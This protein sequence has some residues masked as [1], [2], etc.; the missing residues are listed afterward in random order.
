VFTLHLLLAGPLVGQAFVTAVLAYAEAR[1]EGGNAALAE[2][3][4]PLDGILDACRARSLVRGLRARGRLPRFVPIVGDWQVVEDGGR[5]VLR[6][7]K[8]R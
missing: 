7:D 2:G 6:V 1:G 8:R 4:S 5:K 3:L